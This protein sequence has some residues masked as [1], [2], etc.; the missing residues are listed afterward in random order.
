[1]TRDPDLIRRLLMALEAHPAPMSS[2]DLALP[3]TTPPMV[4]YHVKLLVSAGYLEA[5]ELSTITRF[6]VQILG[7]SWKGHDFLDAVRE[8]TDWQDIRS[9]LQLNERTVPFALIEEVALRRARLA[10][11]LPEQPA[12]PEPG[13]DGSVPSTETE[14]PI[15]T[16]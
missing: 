10:A 6:Q 3:G 5:R 15:P 14:E 1:M 2:F 13:T 4:Q 16:T 7:V 9:A 11:G 12:M 8:E